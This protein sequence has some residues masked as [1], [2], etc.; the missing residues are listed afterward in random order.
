MIVY[1]RTYN[2]SAGALSPLPAEEGTVLRLLRLL[3]LLLLLFL[4]SWP[5]FRGSCPFFCF[6]EVV[7]VN[8][9]FFVCPSALLAFSLHL[10]FSLL[11]FVYH[12]NSKYRRRC[13]VYWK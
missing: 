2:E 13:G 7:F 10:G 4:F 12:T 8:H 1:R 6:R 5:E 9:F 11:C 3:P